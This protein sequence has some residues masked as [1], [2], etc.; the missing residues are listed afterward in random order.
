MSAEHNPPYAYGSR[1]QLAADLGV[2]P[3]Y[4]SAL[5]R[6]G[7][8]RHATAEEARAWIQANPGFRRSSVYI[9]RTSPGLADRMMDL[10]TAASRSLSG[11]LGNS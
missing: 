10:A 3:G 4:V 11:T 2:S 9:S 7:L 8:S 5:R 1:K 6:A